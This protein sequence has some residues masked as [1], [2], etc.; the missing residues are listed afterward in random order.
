MPARGI[1]RIKILGDA[2]G[3]DSAVG[4][5]VDKLKAGALAMGAVFVAGLSK[6]FDVEAATDKMSASLG[7]TAKESERLGGVA[8]R[9]YSQ[10][11][12][13]SMADVTGAVESVVG[14]IRGMRNANAS[15]VEDMTAKVMN[16]ATAFEMEVGRSAQVAG[17]MITSGMARDGVHALDLLTVALQK[18]PKAV[19]EDLVDAIDEYSPFM[20]TVGLTGERAM[21]LL[22]KAAEKGMYGIDKTGDAIKEFTIRA[23]DMSAASKVGFDIIGL[24]QEKMTAKILAGGDTAAG[25]FDKIVKGLLGI[26]DPVKQSQ[27][28]LALFGTPLEDLSTSEIPKFLSSLLNTE[29]GM[30]KVAGAA[31][32]MGDTLNT[33]AKTNLTTFWRT[34][35]MAFVNVVGGKVIPV[36]TALFGWLANMIGPALQAL[37]SFISTFV[38]PPLSA[39]AG[40]VQDNST[41][42]GFLGS[43]LVSGMAAYGAYR[44]ILLLVTAAMRVWKAVTVGQTVAQWALNI[45]MRANPIGLVITA[46]G[47]LVGA[48]IWLWNKSAKFR[49]FFIGVWKAIRPF[50]ASVGEVIGWV[51]GLIGEAIGA[52]NALYDAA[53]RALGKIETGF[54]KGTGIPRMRATGGDV[55]QNVAYTV[56]ERGRELFVPNTDGMIIPHLE[57]EQ[58]I[59]ASSRTAGAT[60]AV[61]AHAARS[62][63]TGGGVTVVHNH[64]PNYVGSKDD[65][66]RAV[67]TG[68]RRAGRGSAERYLRPAGVT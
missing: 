8:G 33:N 52:A 61:A 44:G 49:G 66:V 28:A 9:L 20:K 12:G 23:T 65:I 35:E 39:L 60:A 48:I 42:F 13:E 3:V 18:V 64:F 58:M 29:S 27:A 63:S 22:V 55:M 53:A 68:V 41:A 7:L 1:L 34:M 37:G 51:I 4:I 32:K 43:M 40:F 11:Y 56:G 5:A 31:D 19:R 46:V 14:S 50:V 17:Q 2:K 6:A 57:T 67:R 26:K 45:A 25:A 36:L 62:S 24:S 16:L 15:V 54:Q 10:A 59:A 21:G 30:G 47:A 38:I